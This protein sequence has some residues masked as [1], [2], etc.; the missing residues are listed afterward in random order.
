M[1]GEDF[2]PRAIADPQPIK[3]K[4]STEGVGMR[5]T[6]GRHERAP[7][8]ARERGMAQRQRSRRFPERAAPVPTTG[9]GHRPYLGNFPSI[10]RNF[11]RG[12][13]SANEQSENRY[14]GIGST[15]VQ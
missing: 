2:D 1:L 13:N 6:G 12:A 9:V 15:I 14:K 11:A 7:P 4:K 10:V 3:F 8:L 5:V